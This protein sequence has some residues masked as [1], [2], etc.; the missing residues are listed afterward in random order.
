MHRH[1]VGRD[2]DRR[3]GFA[4]GG[5]ALPYND[6]VMGSVAGQSMASTGGLLLGRRTYDDFYAVWPKRTDNPFTVPHEYPRCSRA[7]VR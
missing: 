1:P 3:D 6:P 7:G 2:E 5:W 4:H